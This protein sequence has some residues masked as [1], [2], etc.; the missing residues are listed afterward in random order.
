MNTEFSLTYFILTI[1]TNKVQREIDEIFL[2][3][4]NFLFCPFG[5]QTFYYVRRQIIKEVRNQNV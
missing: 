5:N 1:K 2:Y 4:V 3:L